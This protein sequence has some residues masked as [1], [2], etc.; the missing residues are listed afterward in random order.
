MWAADRLSSY[1]RICE[2]KGGQRRGTAQHEDVEPLKPLDSV[3]SSRGGKKAHK[4]RIAR[5]N[6]HAILARNS[7]FEIGEQ[8][9]RE[10]LSGT[11]RAYRRQCRTHKV[12][13]SGMTIPT[14][15][16]S[17]PDFLSPNL[18]ILFPI[19][20]YHPLLSLFLCIHSTLSA[21]QHAFLFPSTTSYLPS[22]P[23]LLLPLVFANFLC[24]FDFSPPLCFFLSSCC[25]TS[26]GVL[27]NAHKLSH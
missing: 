22:F 25:S 26:L 8:R 14:N 12:K 24:L 6:T 23:L 4:H 3:T 19:S 11:H 2:G 7:Q 16:H 9:V 13:V 10:G 17:L 5:T 20:P 27:L 18:P 1:A 21:A 15:Y